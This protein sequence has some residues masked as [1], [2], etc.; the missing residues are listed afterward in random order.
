MRSRSFGSPSAHRCGRGCQYCNLRGSILG[1]FCRG[2]P[3]WLSYRWQLHWRTRIVIC[4]VCVGPTRGKPPARIN[5]THFNPKLGLSDGAL[6]VGWVSRANRCRAL[7]GTSRRFAA[8]Q[9]GCHSAAL[10]SAEELQ[11][12]QL[13][14]QF[15][16]Q[17]PHLVRSVP[18][19]R[20]N[21]G[22]PRLP[23]RL[24]RNRHTCPKHSGSI[25]LRSCSR[26]CDELPCTFKSTN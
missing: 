26:T 24:K 15:C 5:S 19:L 22:I 9:L 10:A 12:E 1:R 16:F 2:G 13:S 17:E 8:I 3:C 6:D 25:D 7:V 18:P 23:F 21:S 4:A 14:A 11:C 20:N